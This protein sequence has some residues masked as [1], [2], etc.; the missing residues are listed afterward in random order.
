MLEDGALSGQPTSTNAEWVWVQ[1]EIITYLRIGASNSG[2]RRRRNAFADSLAAAL[3]SADAVVGKLQ[4]QLTLPSSVTVAE[5]TAVQNNL[6][7]QGASGANAGTCS[8]S[9]CTCSSGFTS[10]GNGGCI[11]ITTGS[12]FLY[13]LSLGRILLKKIW[14]IK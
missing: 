6:V 5:T 9:G 11:P 2:R 7:Q 1:F 12:G 4:S 8:T 10:D 13:N 3:A 14:R